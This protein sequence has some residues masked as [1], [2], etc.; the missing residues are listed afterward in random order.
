MSNSTRLFILGS[1]ARGG[2]MHGHQIRQYAQTDRTDLWSDIKVGS[3]Y[4]ALHRME[5]EGVIETVRTEQEGRLPART[6]YAIT[7]DGLLELAALRDAVLRETR[8]RPDPVNLALQ[9]S[10]GM[11]EHELRA[12]LE[13]RYQ[14]WTAQ[15]RSWQR[16]RELAAPH[17]KGF[18]PYGFDHTIAR[19][20]AEVTWHEQLL[21]DL[22]AILADLNADGDADSPEGA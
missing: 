7:D 18:E 14:A 4:G 20:Q 11:S 1:L 8:L 10:V 22:P 16:L 21:K 13:E 15:L 19:V 2:P 9:L 17:L 5:N 3:L 6:I 12:A